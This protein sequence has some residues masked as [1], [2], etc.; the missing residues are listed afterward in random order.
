MNDE[1]T[2]LPF[3]SDLSDHDARSSSSHL[4][5]EL[6]LHG[7]RPFEDDPDPRPLPSSDAAALALESVV[8][9]LSGLLSDT[10]LEADLPD[11]LWSIV[12]LFHRKADRIGRDLDDNEVA[13]RRTQAEQDGSEIRSVELER[14]IAQGLT[15][16]ERR[17]AFEFFRD[18]L[19]ELYSTETGSSWRPRSGSMVNHRALTSAMIDSRDFLNAKK[20]ADTQV[21]LP[22]GSR[23]AFAGGPDCNDHTRIWAT[24]DK[25]RA[26]H[27][28]M[29][30]LHG[31]G[32]K[33]AERIAACWADNRKVAQVA[34]KP[35]WTRH[36]NAAPFKRNDVMLETL[37]IGIIV[38]PG[39]GIVENLAD[40]ARKMGIPVWRFGKEGA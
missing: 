29:V 5:D 23:I 14:L 26:K 4:L 31:A 25:V 39:S 38:F 16:V 22:A 33:G 15:L 35:D 3:E 17:N 36:K 12:N 30:L 32:P 19:S 20:L 10:R 6:A 8:E 21:L 34:F 13:Q 27:P 28:D 37:P 18:Q 1:I 11:L 24:L 9:T 40:K 7:Y 2:S